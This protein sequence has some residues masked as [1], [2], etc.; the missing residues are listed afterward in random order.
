MSN[1]N[2]DEI[3]QLGL[4]V[5]N[6]INVTAQ[7]A[8]AQTE[9]DPAQ[10]FAENVD[11]IVAIVLNTQARTRAEAGLG[12]I[13]VEQA[14]V[15]TTGGYVPPSAPASNVVSFQPAA[16]A[17]QFQPA[18]APAPI[19]L[20]GN[21]T[22]PQVEQA[23]TAFFQAV[24]NNQVAQSFGAARKGQWFDNRQGKSPQAP[25]FKVKGDRGE[26]TPAVWITDKKN[27]AWVAEGLRQVGLA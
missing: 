2:P 17:Q 19:P 13:V 27:P 18:P 16:P 20:A 3:R 1:P 10:Y 6:A 26:Q 14:T 7:L 23:W 22:D 25:D 9:Q 24:N 11:A 8:S 5:G 4:S 21:G 15:P 12:A